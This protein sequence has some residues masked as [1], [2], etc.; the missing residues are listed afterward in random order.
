LVQGFADPQIAP[1]PELPVEVCR[2][3]RSRVMAELDG[4]VA[5]ISAQGVTQGITEDYRQDADFSWLTRINESAAYLVLQ[6]K[7]F[8]LL[9]SAIPRKLEDVEEWISRERGASPAPR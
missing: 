1:P 2:Q 5:L 9:T 8:R 3:R 4:C 7:G 6:P